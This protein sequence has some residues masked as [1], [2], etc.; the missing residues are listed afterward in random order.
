MELKNSIAYENV[1]VRNPAFG[2]HLCRDIYTDRVA[3]LSSVSLVRLP[4]GCTVVPK[5]HFATFTGD[6]LLEEQYPVF[7]DRNPEQFAQILAASGVRENFQQ[8]VLLIARY[9]IFTWGHWLGEL[10]PKVALIERIFPGRFVYALP[11][12]VLSDPR[13]D[14]PWLRIRQ[15]MEA[16]NV[17]S[18][19]I[20]GLDPH[21]LYVFSNL[22]AVSSVWSDHV[23]HPTALKIVRETVNL[24]DMHAT[25][26]KRLSIQRVPGYGRTLLNQ[27]EIFQRLAPRGFSSLSFADLSFAGQVRSFQSAEAVCS[28]LGSDLTGLLYAPAGIKVVALAPAEFGDRFF[29]ALT[30]LRGGSMADVRGPSIPSSDPA[31]NKSDFRIDAADVDV[32]LQRLAINAPV[33]RYG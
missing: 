13:Q 29:Y 3:S 9:G 1:T 5:E 11:A 30:V 24:P 2:L 20:L 12:Q 19:R 33:G 4:P 31:P 6:V 16:Y 15:S 26:S 32:A 18:N 14:L 8:D 22:Y 10:L 21:K 25:P 7:Y 27:E 17:G 23:I 28:V